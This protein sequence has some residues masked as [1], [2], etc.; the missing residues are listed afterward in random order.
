M[1]LVIDVIRVLWMYYMYSVYLSLYFLLSVVHCCP[2]V[3]YGVI[4]IQL[5]PYSPKVNIILH[6]VFLLVYCHVPPLWK[7]SIIVTTW[8]KFPVSLYMNEMK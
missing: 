5:A 1:A 7:F 8:T 6:P 2:N 4:G 3:H